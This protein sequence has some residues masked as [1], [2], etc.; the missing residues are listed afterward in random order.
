[1]NF[2]GKIIE[3]AVG[4]FV[5]PFTGID[6]AN[7]NAIAVVFGKA[8]GPDGIQHFSQL[9]P[10]AQAELIAQAPILAEKH[11]DWPKPLQW[12]PRT[13]TTWVG[14]P[15]PIIEGNTVDDHPIPDNGKWFCTRGY[16]AIT[17][18]DGWHV[19][20]GFRYDDVDRYITFPSAT[21]KRV[22]QGREAQG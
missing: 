12:V 7:L 14:P 9:D 3:I 15:P 22:N 2:I 10:I 5:P 13:V 21:V 11:K 19:R 18:V 17:T 6:E 1:M 8:F 4:L 20:F 16:F